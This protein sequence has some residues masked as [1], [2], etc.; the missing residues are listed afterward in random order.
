MQLLPLFDA[1]KTIIWVDRRTDHEGISL[2]DLPVDSNPA[3]S[4]S[5]DKLRN[6]FANYGKLTELLWIAEYPKDP[7]FWVVPPQHIKRRFTRPLDM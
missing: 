6:L 7:S 3:Y 1:L 4:Y 5:D 2:L